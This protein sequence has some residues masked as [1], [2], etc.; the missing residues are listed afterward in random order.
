MIYK[1]YIKRF[2]DVIVSLL[3]LIIA[4][5]VLLFFALMLWIGN[6][7]T[8]FFLQHRPGKNE[9]IFSIIK[10][11]TMNDKC[12]E[13]GELLP[14]EHRIT[15]FGKVVRKLS[16]DEFPQLI[17]VLKGDMSLIGPRPLLVD[18]LP[19]YSKEQLRRHEIKPG[20]TGWA[21]VNGRNS[22]SWEE[23]FKYDI[24]YVDNVTF[25]NDI[26]ILLLTIK[27]FFNTSDISAD[28]HATM[29][30]FSD[31]VKKLVKDKICVF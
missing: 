17:N 19:Y 25:K 5:P 22:I 14:D 10:F 1:C 21:Q 31:E 7:G 13:K 29:P 3:I 11:K 15:S 27:N 2:I 20:I 18:Y 28:G 4:F 24:W 16:I 6:R 8:P 9:K 26:L 30:R 12:N 23:K